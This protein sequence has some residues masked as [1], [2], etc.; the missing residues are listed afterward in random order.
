MEHQKSIRVLVGGNEEKF[1]VPSSLLVEKSDSFRSACIK[2]WL[3]AKKRT[4]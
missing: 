1:N 4:V 3:E 2:P